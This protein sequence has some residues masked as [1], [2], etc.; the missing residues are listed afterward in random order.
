MYSVATERLKDK[1]REWRN[2]AGLSQAAMA[3][4]LGIQQ[5]TISD[6]ERG[7]AL[8]GIKRASQI[9]DVVGV[10][11]TVVLSAFYAELGADKIILAPHH[12]SAEPQANV[13]A[14]ADLIFLNQ[15]WRDMSVEEREAVMA[16]L[17]AVRNRKAHR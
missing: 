4:A 7:N 6:W 2:A 15:E 10:A 14:D 3:A 16:T 13:E 1:L 17:R 8:P 5:Q 12:G 11:Q 9:A